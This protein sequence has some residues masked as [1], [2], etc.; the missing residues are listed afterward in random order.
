MKKL[1]FILSIT[2]LM[3]CS[4]DDM[5]YCE[6]T[7]YPTT[8]NNTQAQVNTFPVYGNDDE[9]QAECNRQNS[10]THSCVLSIIVP[11]VCNSF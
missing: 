7:H 2:L 11:Q 5:N 3:S 1:L 10:S 9:A 6:C 4:K 8:G